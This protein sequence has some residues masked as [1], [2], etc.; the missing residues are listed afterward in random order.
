MKRMYRAFDFTI[1]SSLVFPELCPAHK[2]VDADL[3]IEFDDLKPLWDEKT[4][5]NYHFVANSHSVMFQ[6]PSTGIFQITDGRKIIISPFSGADNGAIRLFVLGSCL[7]VALLQRKIFPLHGSSVVINGKAYAFIGESGAG[8][9]TLASEFIKLG[10]SMLGDDVTALTFSEESVP[11]VTPAYPQQKLWKDTLQAFGE[12]TSRFNPLFDRQ[13]KFSVPARDCFENHTME[14]AGIFALTKVD[15]GPIRLSQPS[16]ID[17]F[18]LIIKHTYRNFFI[19]DM[20]LNQWHFEMVSRI[21]KKLAIYSIERPS[22]GDFSAPFI[23]SQVLEKV[24]QLQRLKVIQM[25]R[26][27]L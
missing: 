6:I 2:S 4:A 21:V 27:T 16:K 15:H 5:K 3:F 9:S 25:E 14:L 10:Y 13:T 7:G 24:E 17:Q 8:K 12:E 1:S 11:V 26:G 20:G 18:K 22:Q 23:A 19:P